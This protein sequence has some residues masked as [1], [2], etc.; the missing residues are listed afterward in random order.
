M[1]S[2]A[3]AV[4]TPI[5]VPE[6]FP[7]EWEQPEDAHRLWER[8]V[9]HVPTQT[10][11]LDEDLQR[12]VI[13][14]GF[15]GAAE[16]AELPVRNAYRR[17]NTWV[18]QSIAPIS[19][20]PEVL[21]ALGKKAGERI[22]GLIGTQ[23]ERWHGEVLPDLERMYAEFAAL[24][25]DGDPGELAKGVDT[26]VELLGQAWKHHFATVLPMLMSMSL[27][28]DLHDE[29]LGSE[30]GFEAYRLLQGQ[31]NKSLEADRALFELSRSALGKPVVLD[32]LQRAAAAD[33]RSEL[34][35]TDEGRDFLR[36]LDAYLEQ[37]GKRLPFYI[38]FSEPSHIEDPTPVLTSLKDAVTRPDVDQEAELAGLAQDAEALTAAARE[39]V[40]GLPKP[41]REQFEYLLSA[42]RQGLVMQ[43]DHNFAI[44]GRIDYEVRQVF[45]AAGRRLN[46]DGVLAEPG[47]VFH[48]RL[49]EI[50]AALAGN[51]PAD[52]AER[53]AERKAEIERWARVQWPPLL[54]TLPPGAPPDDAFGRALARM[55]G[56]VPRESEAPGVLHGM[57][58]SPGVARGT[59]RVLRSLAEADRLQAGD[60]LVCETTAPPWTPLFGR[61]AAI[62]TDA[63]GILSHCAVVAREY[64]IPAV[65]GTKAG[66]AVIRDG[67]IVEV[68]GSSGTVRIIE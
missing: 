4:P 27:F 60:V 15:N 63:G 66:T 32:V 21:E 65:V 38:T 24:D 2:E 43:E 47:D 3:T 11:V 45:V 40:A 57:R 18:Y 23:L 31:D 36:G 59:A 35:Q 68:D 1:Q 64:G 55:F 51:P 20:D 62:V 19:H 10:T 61:A 67:Q 26:A 16:E 25:L 33:V 28:Q 9:M 56:A 42:A 53:I 34:E 46:A 44:D 37:W 58:G 7:V 14:R 22:G 39:R 17:F 12:I 49:E 13:D 48:L 50:R 52:A 30:D 8:E 41:V 5:P 6:G 54:G 29:L